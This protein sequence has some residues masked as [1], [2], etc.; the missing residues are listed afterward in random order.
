MY[1][2]NKHPIKQE[3]LHGTKIKNNAEEIWGWASHAGKIR[4][5]RRARYFI[6]L[7]KMN[8][9]SN[10]L[11][12]GCGSS[13]FTEILAKTG[14]KLTATDISAELLDLAKKKNI[15]G[16][17]FLLTD[18]H[19]L[20][21]RDSSFDIVLGSSVLHHLEVE[22]AIQEFFRVLKPNGQVIFAEPNMLNPQIFLQKNIPFIK[23]WMNDSADE[24]AIVRWEIAKKLKLT[25][26][27]DIK[28]FPYDFLHPNTPQCLIKIVQH[29]GA[30]IEMLPLIKEFAGSL[31]I[32]GR[33]LS[34]RC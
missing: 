17:S 2:K 19:T 7:T 3:I 30:A 9:N 21:F 16:C 23:R 32:Y 28:A 1:I 4:A 25:G 13:V 34:F 27:K 29:I 10:V 24:T 6:E 8:P 33:K 14:A 18:A 12:I 26:F 22:K 31:I 15:L 5:H 11:E 20:N